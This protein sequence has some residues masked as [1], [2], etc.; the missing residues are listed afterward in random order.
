MRSTVFHRL[1]H[2]FRAVARGPVSRFV[3]DWLPVGQ[4]S[5]RGMRQAKR[6]RGG[7]RVG[8][9]SFEQLERREVFSA[10]YH[11]G[12]LIQHVEAQPVFLGPTWTSNPT[13]AEQAAA[14][15][16]YV[17]YLVQSPYMDVMTDAGYNVGQGTA[18]TGARINN[19]TL[20]ATITDAA[21]R[22]TLQQLINRSQVAP[23]TRDRVYLIY[24]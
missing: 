5:G 12:F 4:S 10:S 23:P 20:A 7:Q 1:S 6:P 15:D 24:I 11:G 9:G 22:G 8:A 2:L 21:I 18:I 14:I 16:R 3:L 17:P 19:V 13:L